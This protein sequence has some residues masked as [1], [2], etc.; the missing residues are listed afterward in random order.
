MIRYSI[1]IFVLI[2][3]GVCK[4]DGIPKGE[5]MPMDFGPEPSKDIQV[6]PQT[7]KQRE[8][9]QNCF[10][11]NFMDDSKFHT[12]EAMYILV[13]EH[14]IMTEYKHIENLLQNEKDGLLDYRD[15]TY[16]GEWV[17]VRSWVDSCFADKNELPNVDAKEVLNLRN[18]NNYLDEL[19]D[20]VFEEIERYNEIE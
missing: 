10:K 11:N 16:L 9:L 12:K 2:V 8:S 3:G 7:K 14:L 17:I 13:C 1:L 4:G 15:A 19:P 5:E 18:Y 6:P 20:E